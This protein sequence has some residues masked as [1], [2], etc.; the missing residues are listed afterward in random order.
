M[1]TEMGSQDE[2]RLC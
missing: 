2:C 1:N